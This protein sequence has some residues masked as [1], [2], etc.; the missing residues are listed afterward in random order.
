VLGSRCEVR[1]A[2]FEMKG[3]RRKAGGADWARMREQ[4]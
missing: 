1:G 2:R 4:I 3:A